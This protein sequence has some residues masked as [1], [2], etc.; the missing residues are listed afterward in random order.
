[1][2]DHLVAEVHAA[3]E[4]ERQAKAR[5]SVWVPVQ[6]QHAAGTTAAGEGSDT[7]LASGSG[8]GRAGIDAVE[9]TAAARKFSWGS[10]G[11]VKLPQASSPW[12]TAA[13][14]AASP[15]EDFPSTSTASATSTALSEQGRH[16][17]AAQQG[18]SPW[19]ASSADSYDP[20]DPY[21]PVMDERQSR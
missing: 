4:R 13:T 10:W 6:Q 5:P 1:M 21:A 14:A 16:S 20:G 17:G 18:H 9:G 11:A 19:L 8:D 7:E 3:K 2:R 12:D 15:V